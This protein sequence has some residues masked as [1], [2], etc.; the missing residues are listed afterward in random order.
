MLPVTTTPLST[1]L[2]IVVV[3]SGSTLAQ[4]VITRG[5]ALGDSPLVSLHDVMGDVDA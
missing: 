1:L 3:L 5:D 4:E 2:A